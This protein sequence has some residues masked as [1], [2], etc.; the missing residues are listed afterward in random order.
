MGSALSANVVHIS[1]VEEY[2]KHY[3]SDKPMVTMYSGNHC[4]PC[5]KMKPHFKAAAEATADMTFCIVDTGKKGLGK[6][7]KGITGIPRLVFSHKGKPVKREVG[8]MSRSALDT[9]INNF[10]KTIKPAPKPRTKQPTQPTPK[11]HGEKA[12][13]KRKASKAKKS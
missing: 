11:P 12:P 4:N 9:S 7:V 6:L 13:Q 2:H 5:Q 3:T 8:G 1:S 10:R